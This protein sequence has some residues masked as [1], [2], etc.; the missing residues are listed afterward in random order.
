MINNNNNTSHALNN[1][2]TRSLRGIN[3]VNYASKNS[4][5]NLF[6]LYNHFRLCFVNYICIQRWDSK[7]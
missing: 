4:Y 2:L 1:I 3:V 7:F 6:I 5:I